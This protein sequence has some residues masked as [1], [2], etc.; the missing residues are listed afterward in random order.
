M[1]MSEAWRQWCLDRQAEG[2]KFSCKYGMT[3]WYMEDD[4]LFNHSHELYRIP[5][6]PLPDGLK[7]WRQWCLDRQAEGVRFDSFDP[8]EG[9]WIAHGWWCFSDPG[10]LIMLPECYRIAAQPI[11]NTQENEMSKETVR[12]EIDVSKDVDRIV[13]YV[14]GKNAN[15]SNIPH[16]AAGPAVISFKR[17]DSW[18]PAH[19]EYFLEGYKLDKQAFQKRTTPARELTVEEVE[20]LLGYKVK[21]VGGAE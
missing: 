19:P 8:K 4:F 13:V 18:H 17:Q 14:D 3:V 15:G 2:M 1:E 7:D 20:K 6:Q 9:E 16:N 10:D 5:A 12:L 21:I 11:P